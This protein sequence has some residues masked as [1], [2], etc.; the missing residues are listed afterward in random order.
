[1]NT[2]NLYFTNEQDHGTI[3]WPVDFGAC[4]KYI[5]GREGCE[6]F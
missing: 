3:N 2:K 5:R 1:M 4:A 6:S